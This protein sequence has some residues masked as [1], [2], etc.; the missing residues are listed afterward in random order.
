L[1]GKRDYSRPFLIFD[2]RIGLF[3]DI[4]FDLQVKKAILSRN[5]ARG[6]ILRDRERK[7]ENARTSERVIA[8]FSNKMCE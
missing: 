7:N 6:Q 5:A 4:F 3:Q 8:L 2:A 1:L